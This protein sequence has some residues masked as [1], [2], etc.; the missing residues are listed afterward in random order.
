M[1][2][3]LDKVI[4]FGRSLDEYIKMFNLSN[5][6][7]GN[8]ILGVGDG[9]ASFNAE[10]T[11]IGATI[12]SIDPIYQFSAIEVLE[13]FYQVVDD[14][15]N[16]VRASSDDYVWSYHQSPDDLRSNRV[17]VI[18][19]F[20]DDYDK[21]K[22]ERRYQMEALP[23]LRFK[24]DKYDIALCSHFLF[25]YSEHH[26]YRF[27][28]DSIK[29][30]LRVSREVRIFPLLTLML[31]QSSHLNQIIQE[32]S[33]LGYIVSITTVNYELQKGGNQ[34]LTLKKPE[35]MH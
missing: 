22:Q 16:Q 10:A 12:T 18:N 7:L 11:K 1:A 30:M 9:P 31:Q 13:R 25:L 4:P 26:D 17:Q 28:C 34:M 21:G 15:I 2:V 35:R 14:V 20:I 24:D 19:K 23:K 27:H 32:F 5:S 29:E 8:R 6:D 3:K 33:Q